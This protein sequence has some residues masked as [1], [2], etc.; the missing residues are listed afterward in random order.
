LQFLLEKKPFDTDRIARWA[1]KVSAKHSSELS[2]DLRELFQS[3]EMMHYG[4]GLEYSEE[5]LRAIADALL[6][7]RYKKDCY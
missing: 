3:L 1:E 4:T 6:T 5:K 2:D 7:F